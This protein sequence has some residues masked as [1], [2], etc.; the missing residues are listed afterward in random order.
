MSSV[1]L[2]AIRNSLTHCKVFFKLYSKIIKL[3]KQI[4][5]GYIEKDKNRYGISLSPGLYFFKK[6]INF[7]MHN[8]NNFI[9][10]ENNIIKIIYRN[11]NIYTEL[12]YNHVLCM[13]KKVIICIT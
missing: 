10:A 12:Y 11:K 2:V 6:K 5:I 3:R 4:Q 7:K 13:L 8:N 1:S 9:S